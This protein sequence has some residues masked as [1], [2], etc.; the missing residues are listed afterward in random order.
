MQAISLSLS[1]NQAD[2]TSYEEELVK[3][4]I[5]WEIRHFVWKA[6]DCGAGGGG[7]GGVAAPYFFRKKEDLF[8]SI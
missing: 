1:K 2:V 3:L 6:R 5:L 8:V 7:G 4:S